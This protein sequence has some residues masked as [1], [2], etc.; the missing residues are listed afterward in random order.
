MKR[1]AGLES[2]NPQLPD[3]NLH[4]MGESLLPNAELAK[5]DA[6]PVEVARQLI[7]AKQ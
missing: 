6:D 5:F 3:R 7:I 2:K 1:M 4:C